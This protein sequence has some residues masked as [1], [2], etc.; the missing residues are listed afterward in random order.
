[1]IVGC[2]GD[3]VF[4]VRPEVVQTLDNIKWTGKARYTAHERHLTHALTEFCG[5]DPD[6]IAF[7]ILLSTDLGAEPMTEINKIW[8]YERAG[9][10][11]PLVIGD[12]TYGI[13][14]WVIGE[15]ETTINRSDPRGNVATATVAI[16]LLEYLEE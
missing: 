16:K 4:K 2:L 10:A 1:M 9:T 3:I 15:H 8:G 5:L 14:R 12:K 11:V 13:Y 6:E 7:E